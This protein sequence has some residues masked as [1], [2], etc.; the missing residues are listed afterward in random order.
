MPAIK[1]TADRPARESVEYVDRLIRKS[2]GRK[3]RDVPHSAQ[4][5]TGRLFFLFSVSIILLLGKK[6]LN[7]VSKIPT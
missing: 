1:P 4:P 5:D 6:A 2:R 7:R 3:Q